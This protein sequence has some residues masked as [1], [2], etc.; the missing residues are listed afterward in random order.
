MYQIPPRY[1]LETTTPRFGEK[2]DKFSTPFGCTEDLS[3]FSNAL[4][5]Q[6]ARLGRLK[7]SASF[8]VM[9]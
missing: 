1:A 7:F 5:W 9:H 2:N 6:R 8:D 3:S 4:V